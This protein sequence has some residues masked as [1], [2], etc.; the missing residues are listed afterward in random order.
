MISF[1]PTEDQQLV[2]DTI[3]RF[4]KE[5][6]Q[7]V[8]HDSDE[9][10][11]L[12]PRVVAEGWSLGLFAG[13]V[14]EEY[15]GLGEDYSTVSALL[16][17]E[18]L[19][20]GDLSLALTLLAPSLVGLPVLLFG[21]P[22][23]K[24][25]WLPLLVGDQF[26]PLTA[27]LSEAGWKFDPNHPGTT[28]QSDGE[29]YVLNG[30]KVLVPLAEEAEVVL[31]YAT[32][33]GAT[34]AYLVEKGAAGMIIGEREKNLGLQALP[35]YEVKFENCRVPLEAR[36]G[37]E[38]GC[39][40]EA[41]LNHSRVSLAALAVGVAKAALEYAQDYAKD[42][43]AF[44][45][46]IA[47]FQSIA[48]MLAEMA[49]ELEAARLMAWEAA[50]RLDSDLESTREC[51]LAKGNA[52]DMALMVTDRALQILGGHGYIREHPVEMY[53]RNARVFAVSPGLALV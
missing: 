51:V 25:R 43:Q 1:Q 36:L 45:R 10:R 11:A 44:G 33:N 32:E 28:A 53:L 30:H 47:Q 21:T 22:G 23:Q 38:K 52:D 37:G 17:A 40:I 18:E 26:R 20:Y 24:T 12:P 15:G 42:R 49:F 7:K 29:G 14:P 48:F 34:Q 8:R 50:W 9:D 3:R 35:T 5:R 41:I 31:V 39:D 13:W 27:A 46:A 4:V 19:A 16:Y 6:V 2:I